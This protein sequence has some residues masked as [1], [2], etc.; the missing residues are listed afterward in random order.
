[1]KF[2][3][4]R[5]NRAG[6]DENGRPRSR[7]EAFSESRA[8]VLPVQALESITMGKRYSQPPLPSSSFGAG[9]LPVLV[10]IEEIWARSSR[11]C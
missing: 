6:Q 5:C 7:D 8:V 9:F 11:T 4:R 1:M 3:M 10:Q 2:V